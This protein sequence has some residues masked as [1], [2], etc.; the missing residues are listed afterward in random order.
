MTLPPMARPARSYTIVPRP[1][2]FATAFAAEHMY[3]LHTQ[4]SARNKM[5]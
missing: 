5:V 1:A 4:Q 2:E 3:S